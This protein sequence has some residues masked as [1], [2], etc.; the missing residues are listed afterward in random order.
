MTVKFDDLLEAFE[1]VSA[2]QPFENEAYLCRETG[3]IHFHS[4]LTDLDDALPDDVDT[5]EKYV[6]IPHKND[7]E[8]GKRLALRFADDL[9][10]DSVDDVHDIFRHKGA[11]ARFK[12]LLEHRG[13]LQQWYEY[14]ESSKKAA[15]RRW[16]EENGIEVQG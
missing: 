7:L 16:C 6:A 10:P 15:L 13:M 3:V 2:G 4:E 14:E 9:L 8:L 11:Y 1:L 5:S 12:R